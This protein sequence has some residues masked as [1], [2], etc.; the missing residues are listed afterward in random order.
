[1]DGCALRRLVIA[2][3]WQELCACARANARPLTSHFFTGFGR[4]SP[5]LRSSHLS[6]RCLLQAKNPAA[7]LFDLIKQQL[8]PAQVQSDAVATLLLGA[9]I[10][11]RARA[12]CTGVYQYPQGAFQ[13]IEGLPLE[14]MRRIERAL[15]MAAAFAR[16]LFDDPSAASSIQFCSG[17]AAATCFCARF[18]LCLSVS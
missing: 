14:E 12:H 16:K 6:Q 7:C 3:W 9:V 17:P 2:D 15:L 11:D 1:M 5:W 13:C 4:S 10:G 18:S 8:S